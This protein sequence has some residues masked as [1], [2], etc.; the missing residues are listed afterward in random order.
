MAWLKPVPACRNTRPSRFHRGSV[1]WG[2]R[3]G[4]VHCTS[5]PRFI[6][7]GRFGKLPAD[8]RLSLPARLHSRKILAHDRASLQDKASRLSSAFFPFSVFQPSPQFFRKAAG[9]RN[10][11]LQRLM[12]SCGFGRHSSSPAADVI[13]AWRPWIGASIM[14]HRPLSRRRSAIGPV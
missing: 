7:P 14:R 10:I 2:R 6:G 13:R 12:R 3:I 9:L 5:A 4:P 8:N 1:C 11:P